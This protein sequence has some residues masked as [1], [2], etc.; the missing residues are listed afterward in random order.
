MKFAVLRDAH[1]D[2]LYISGS[3]NESRTALHLNAENIDVHCSWRGADSAARVADAERRFALLWADEN[4]AMRVM[5]LP[6]AVQ[7]RLI[8]FAKLS[9]LR[10]RQAPD[11]ASEFAEGPSLTPLERLRFALLRDGPRLPN[12]R[13]GWHRHRADR[14]L[15]APG[16]CRAPTRRLL[17]VLVAALRR[18]RAR[19]DDRSWAGHCGRCIC[20]A[21]PKRIL[22]AAPASLTRQWQREMASKFLLPFGRARSGSPLR[23]EYLLPSETDRPAAS[24]CEPELTIVSTGLLVRH[25]RREELQRARDFDV[26][27]SMKPT[28][29]AAAIR[30][31]EPAPTRSLER[32]I[33]YWRRCCE[34]RQRR[35]SSRQRRPCSFDPIEATDLV[36]LMRRAGPFLGDPSVLIGYYDAL[37]ALV[38]GRDLLPVEWEFLRQAIRLVEEQD[39]PLW[40]WL[41]ANVIDGR[42]A[43]AVRRW[44]DDGRAPQGLDRRNMLRLIFAASPLSR[45]MLRHTRPLLEIYRERGRLGANL[46]RARDP[47]DADAS[48]SAS[49]R[50]RSTKR[51]RITARVSPSALADGA[52][53]LA[54]QSL[55][56]YLS[57]LRLR[58][59]S[60]LYAIRETLRR[61]RDRVEATSRALT[62]PRKRQRDGA[63]RPACRRRG[64]RRDRDRRVVAGPHPG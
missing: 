50:R 55:G 44:L 38:N 63:R 1:D 19:K 34:R 14:A 60:S 22:I 62:P 61:R 6:E 25:D 20:P 17:P 32:C 39:P 58:F 12:G 51:W 59:A 7:R 49:T 33:G 30:R 10:R 16:G 57:F 56:F 18:G 36:S 8:E 41:T 45:V 15:A 42:T 31:A 40:D 46:A 21:L 11:R 53:A 43:L 23:H 5:P 47:A 48:S 27:C 37:G 24:L 35:F 28:T 4:A 13:S 52:T 3:L 64:G 2:R 29:R 54:T 26:I 9:P